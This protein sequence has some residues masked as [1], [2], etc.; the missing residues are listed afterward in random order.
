MAERMNRTLLEKVRCM[1]FQAKL[2]KEFWAEA[3]LYACQIINCLPAAANEGKTP[4]QVWSGSS[5]TD[6]DSF[7]IFGCHAYYHVQKSK[8]D[9]R[10]KKAIFMGFSSGV[11][12]YR[13][14]CLETKKIIHSR[15]VK[16][17]KSE[18]VKTIKQVDDST[19]DSDS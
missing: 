8:L 15:D 10:A 4:L 19:V 5:A 14:W 17:N 12:G 18:I 3:V 2:G 11:K 1:L 6:Y 9:P 16:F 13:L 7:H